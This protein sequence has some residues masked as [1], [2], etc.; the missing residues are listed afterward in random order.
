M[1]EEIYCFATTFWTKRS[2]VKY[3]HDWV[4]CTWMSVKPSMYS[5][6]GPGDLLKSLQKHFG[7]DAVG[8]RAAPNMSTELTLA[9]S[10]GR[11]RA[12]DTR[13]RLLAE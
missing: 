7:S 2:S 13:V 6:C 12:V 11:R 5:L 9:Y 1:V 8:S 3:D 4:A 10:S